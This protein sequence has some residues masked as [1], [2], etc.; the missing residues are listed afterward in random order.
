M[1]AL[2]FFASAVA[3]NQ[4]E[5][6]PAKGFA[7]FSAEDTFHPYEFTRHAIGDNDIQIEILYAG[8]CHSD[9]HAAWDEQQEQG[10]Y[11]SYPM[12][13]GHEIAGR[14]AKAGK[15]VTIFKVGDIAPP[16]RCTKSSSAK[17]ARPLPTIPKTSTTKAR[18]R[19]A[20]TRTIL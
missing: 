7:M 9:L 14:A 3:Q 19:W 16:A 11:A 4:T 18:W 2:A 6:V 13:P 5:R 1:T 20:A 15:N 17:R 12:I 8:I 10:L